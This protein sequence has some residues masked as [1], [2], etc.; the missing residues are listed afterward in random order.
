M[1]ASATSRMDSRRSIEVFW[2]QRKASG[3]VSPILVVSRDFARATSLRVANYSFMSETSRSSAA[4]SS[5]REIAISIAGT[6]SSTVNG[7]TT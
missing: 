5:K 2:I 4:I 1:I 7:L 6:T 3:S